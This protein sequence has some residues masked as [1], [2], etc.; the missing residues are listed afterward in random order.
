MNLHQSSQGILD[1]ITTGM[2][3]DWSQVKVDYS[4]LSKIYE[5]KVNLNEMG[6][7]FDDSELKSPPQ[8]GVMS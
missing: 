7:R 3:T 6:F 4:K 1:L 8:P 5:I 2:V